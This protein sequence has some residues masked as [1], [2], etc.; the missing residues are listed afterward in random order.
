M[1]F[2]VRLL[3]MKLA[4]FDSAFVSLPSFPHLYCY[5]RRNKPNH[6]KKPFFSYRTSPK[7]RNKKMKNLNKKTREENFFVFVFF[8]GSFVLFVCSF[9]F[10]PPKKGKKTFNG[11]EW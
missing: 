2:A 6:K 11:N 4:T 8:F 10:D 1:T 7:Y 3:F 5:Q 9:E